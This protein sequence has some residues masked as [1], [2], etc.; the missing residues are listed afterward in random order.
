MNS[1]MAA[2]ATAAAGKFLDGIQE[3]ADV[4]G[5]HY[6]PCFR[7]CLGDN[8]EWVEPL[9]A[10]LLLAATTGVDEQHLR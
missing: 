5:P 2:M 9:L 10:A 6:A 8:R 4:D 3:M 1:A 7:D